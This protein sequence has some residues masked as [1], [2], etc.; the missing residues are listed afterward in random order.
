MSKQLIAK[1]CCFLQ[2][3]RK[4]EENCNR[5]LSG[6]PSSSASEI[7]TIRIEEMIQNKE[8]LMVSEIL[9]ELRL[10]YGIVHHITS[11]VL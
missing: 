4:D 5:I 1:W 11:N 2:S 3:D 7:N 8:Q 9:S 10:S 6:H